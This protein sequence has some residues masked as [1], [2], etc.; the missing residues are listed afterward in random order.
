VDGPTLVALLA[1]VG[2]LA[3]VLANCYIGIHN[4]VQI[5][6]V[7]ELAN[8]TLTSVREE[9]NHVKTTEA[10][11]Q[12]ATMN[13]TKQ[14]AG[15]SPPFFPAD[16]LP[17]WSQLKGVL[18]SGLPDSEEYNDC[19][20]T[21]VAMLVAAVHGVPVEP[22]SVRQHLHGYDGSGLTDGPELV[23]ALRYYSTA[24]HV[25]PLSG[26]TAWA[27]IGGISAQER[28]VI[29]LGHW[30]GEGTALH[31]VVTTGLSHSIVSF[32]DPWSGTRSY[33]TKAQFLALEAGQIVV[34][35]SHLHYDCRGWPDPT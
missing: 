35:D 17:A 23:S 14:G 34:S 13:L 8:G 21:C 4:G 28:N 16:R 32:N 11:R 19:G 12:A 27:A 10:V 3:V 29:I 24:A 18:P 20:E 25:E 22:G 31:W 5:G 33:M 2:S 1:A 6:K 15:V 9:L 26:E 7:H 30:E